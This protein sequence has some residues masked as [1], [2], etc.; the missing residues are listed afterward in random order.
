[1][2]AILEKRQRMMAA[3]IAVAVVV[4]AAR[5]ARGQTAEDLQ[6]ELN[7]M[8]AQLEQLQEKMKQQ[9][10]LIKKLSTQKPQAPAAPAAVAVPA[11]PAAP[12]TA[13]EQDVEQ[14][15]TEKVL[16]TI[17]PSLTAA[18]KTFPSQF[19]PA[20]SVAID[21]VG[22]Y[23]TQTKANFEFRAAELGLSASIDPFARGYAFING[24]SDGVEV[25]EAALVTTS[26]PYNLTFKG[27]RFFA[28]FGR[29]SKFH[30][31][32]LPFVNRPVVL[33]EYVDGESQADGIELSY[34]VPLEQYVTLTAGWYNKIG[35]ENERVS[36]LV[37]RDLS[38]FSYLVRPATFISLNDANS[39]D[40]GM[41]EAYTPSVDSYPVD[42]GDV[43]RDGKAR[44]LTGLDIT[45][46]Y[47][48]LATAAYNGLVW[49]TEVLYNRENWN[50]DTEDPADPLFQ[51]QNAVGLYSYIEP[52]LTRRYYVGFLFQWVQAIDGLAADTLGYSPYVTIF[53]SEFQRIRLQYQYLDSPG[54]H[55]NQFFLQ[56]TGFLGSHVHTF[57]DR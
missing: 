39:I 51:W 28:D 5:W 17:Q 40:L 37:P 12:A 29:L 44:Y 36:N 49:G 31:H 47:T 18:N 8:K 1:M 15:V 50:V 26:L 7:A 52:R 54:L 41:T 2:G 25:E 9:E 38:Q 34:L 48:P 24:T 13:E 27:G 4:A 10:Q 42:V 57:R 43:V 23:G 16:R 3:L 45:Y 11:A 46:R 30:D 22:S 6:R 20:I 19:N 14:R 35:V 21:M 33:D 53:V 32:D 56:W 55:D